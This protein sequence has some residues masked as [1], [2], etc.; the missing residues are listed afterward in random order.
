MVNHKQMLLRM[1]LHVLSDVTVIKRQEYIPMDTLSLTSHLPFFRGGVLREIY[2][3]KKTTEA[4]LF[5]LS[6]QITTWSCFFLSQ[7]A[8][9]LGHSLG[10][11]PDSSSGGCSQSCHAWSQPAAAN[12]HLEAFWCCFQ[13]RH[14][15]CLSG[16][17]WASPGPPGLPG[18]LRNKKKKKKRNSQSIK[19]AGLD[20]CP[21]CKMDDLKVGGLWSRPLV[22]SCRN[23]LAGPV[24]RRL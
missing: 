9:M 4:L 12:F 15:T 1:L 20:K 21:R 6:L 5:P 11:D 19:D 22:R 10:P 13:S 17:S 16:P 14:S 24:A 23:F 2:S 18:L 3:R 8:I 7:C